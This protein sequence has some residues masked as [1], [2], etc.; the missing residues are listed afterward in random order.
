[1]VNKIVIVILILIPFSFVSYLFSDSFYKENQN[2]YN[3]N[4]YRKNSI[5][6]KTYYR[7]LIAF[8][9]FKDGNKK[10]L[11][12]F[13]KIHEPSFYWVAMQLWEG[14]TNFNNPALNIWKEFLNIE[15]PI[16][17]NNF[18]KNC[19]FFGEYFCQW[20]NDIEF[21]YNQYY[22]N[23]R[24]LR[25]EDIEAILY[26]LRPYLLQNQ[27]IPFM[28]RTADWLPFYLNQ[29]G[30]SVEASI[31]LSK[32]MQRESKENQKLLIK[33]LVKSLLLSGNP[34]Y[35][36]KV[37]KENHF[38]LE[39]N[40]I[41]SFNILIMT[42]NYDLIIKHLLGDFTD[43]TFTNQVD[44]WT[45]FPISKNLIKIRFFEI[46]H[47]KNQNSREVL[48][49]L[50]NL[51]KTENLSELEKLYLRLIQSKILYKTNIE[52]AQK[53]AE[54]V[55]FKA[56]EKNLFLLEYYA[57]IWNGWCF[58]KQDKPYPANIEFTKAFYIV[59]KHFPKISKYSV[60]LG[61]FLTK[62]KFGIT[63]INIVKQLHIIYTEYFPNKD[64]FYFLEWLPEDISYDVWKEIYINFLFSTKN[65]K[66]LFDFII[67][68]YTKNYFFENSKNPGGTIGIYT[69]TLWR[70]R[71]QNESINIS[72]SSKV[73]N[74]SKFTHFIN[75]NSKDFV[76]FIKTSNHNF[77]IIFS[78]KGVFLQKLDSNSLN[79]Y[80]EFFKRYS[81]E[82]NLEIVLNPEV[83]L[84][85][86]ELLQNINIS[87]TQFSLIYLNEFN[88]KKLV[89]THTTTQESMEFCNIEFL[90]NRDS[91]VLPKVY[92]IYPNYPFLVQFICSENESIRLWDMERFIKGNKRIVLPLLR[93][94]P[95][96]AALLLVSTR[97]NWLIEIR[98]PLLLSIKSFDSI[99]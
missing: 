89:Q 32:M 99:F 93:E 41:N 85:F 6:S 80:G 67:K 77:V 54:D 64:Y 69:S 5:S 66:E 72:F 53:I 76:F 28:Y 25:M 62:R 16:S 34:E 12:E 74:Y 49:Q 44:I 23:Q 39:E 78:K 83:N 84:S 30:L 73:Y 3:L 87:Q 26:R 7:N 52:L 15:K 47:W 36:Y 42:Q 88:D 2:L 40:Y 24:K 45:Y 70:K 8:Y 96:W 19:N 86:F 97:K 79:P 31:L 13:L 65:H 4:D 43:K 91:I 46:L 57:T 18:K 37:Y 63:D 29:I 92:K 11:L 94:Q 33:E 22:Q 59:H 56:Q 1:M 38:D 21:L 71:F 98:D 17:Y 81:S 50:E 61:L 9:F 95:E 48:S 10:E 82:K 20:L 35:A 60:L 90:L 68:E 27:Y 14:Q 51:Q 58:Y 55:Q 75:K